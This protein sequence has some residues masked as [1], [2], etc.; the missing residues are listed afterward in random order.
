MIATWGKGAVASVLVVF[1]LVLG[2][3]SSDAPEFVKTHTLTLS[4]N[5]AWPQAMAIRSAQSPDP[6]LW[7][8]R[9]VTLDTEGIKTTSTA[10]KDLETGRFEVNDIPDDEDAICHIVDEEEALVTTISVS[11]PGALG[12]VRDVFR[13]TRDAQATVVYDSLREM[14]VAHGSDFSFGDVEERADLEG[15]WEMGCND[16]RDIVTDEVVEEV[17]CTDEVEGDEL[18]LHRVTAS[19][20]NGERR[21]AYGIWSSQEA[22]AGC[23]YTEGLDTLPFGW[24]L[25]Q[26]F[27]AQPS[28]FVFSAPF[29]GLTPDS[30]SAQIMTMIRENAA[31]T[32]PSYDD[33]KAVNEVGCVSEKRCTAWYYHEMRRHGLENAGTVCW[34]LVIFTFEG[35]DGITAGL[36][37]SGGGRA[38]PLGRLH[39]I[40]AFEYGNE[41][42][43][44]SQISQVREVYSPD[45]SVEC[46]LKEEFLMAVE[47][48]DSDEDGSEDVDEDDAEI[49]AKEVSS[50][51][52]LIIVG[53]RLEARYHSST[54]VTSI[55]GTY[56]N[57]CQQELGEE[58]GG[59]EPG[60]Y[61]DVVLES[62]TA[63]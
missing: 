12:G 56:D 21:M 45:E 46:K 32:M 39:F 7:T 54:K 15:K 3:C 34:P 44:R 63:L 49:V 27:A 48:P 61:S 31:E 25:D 9:C 11:D 29:E 5:V 57:L 4:I 35:G 37:P 6:A 28:I 23:G 33:F 20:P 13:L 53:T 16:V 38:K 24:S 18:F 19:G 17:R 41:T 8:V 59:S 60:S 47:I 14:S 10:T 30:T 51:E 2:A 22:F 26:I 42:Y 43:M 55:S 58:D 36:W 1:A 50:D 52:D 62:I 40:E